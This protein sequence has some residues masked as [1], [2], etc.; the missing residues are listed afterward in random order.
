MHRKLLGEEITNKGGGKPLPYYTERKNNMKTIEKMLPKARLEGKRGYYPV[1]NHKEWEELPAVY[2][3]MDWFPMEVSTM[4]CLGKRIEEKSVV[5][6]VVFDCPYIEP[7]GVSGKVSVHAQEVQKILFCLFGRTEC[8]LYSI[9]E[10]EFQNG[11]RRAAKWLQDNQTGAFAIV[12]GGTYVA[13][14]GGFGGY[15]PARITETE[16]GF[17]YRQSYQG[18]FTSHYQYTNPFP[19]EVK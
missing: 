5:K 19:K 14:Q 10:V 7:Y 17:E 3:A 8:H 6:N 16:N 2:K 18:T 12:C 1:T 13:K 4:N 11:E 15:V 9:C